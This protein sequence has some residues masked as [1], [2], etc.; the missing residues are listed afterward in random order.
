M[1]GVIYA[2]LLACVVVGSWE[3]FNEAESITGQEAG[4]LRAMYR[5]SAQLPPPA[6]GTMRALVVEYAGDVANGEW[7]IMAQGSASDPHVSGVLDRMSATLGGVVPTTPA[8]P[9][10]LQ[11]QVDRLNQLVGLRSQ[12]LDYVDQGLPGVL[13]VALLLGAVVTIGFAMLFGL[14]R[15]ALHLLMVGSLTALIGVLLFVITVI[16]FPFQGSVRVEPHALERVLS[17]LTQ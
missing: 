4:V 9:S 2:V 11:G 16:D 17:D 7:A 15:A 12:R 6:S 8:G 13:W 1:V 5:D 10:F 14:Q 3:K